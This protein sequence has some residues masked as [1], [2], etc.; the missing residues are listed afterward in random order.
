MNN[1]KFRNLRT[2]AIG[3]TL[4]AG[5]GAAASAGTPDTQYVT[6][7]IVSYVVRFPDLD[8]SKA[9]GAAVLYHRLG[10]A[11]RIVCTPLESSERLNS[12]PYR[13]CL[14]QAVAQAVASINRPMLSQYHAARV[15]GGNGSVQ[16]AKAD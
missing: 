13:E 12:A 2:L 15:K 10:H 3:I 6:D 11:A 4:A 16:L 5:I 14:A 8:L 7:G 9:D 1:V